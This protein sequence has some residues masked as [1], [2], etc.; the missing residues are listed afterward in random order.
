VAAQASRI[1][2]QASTVLF[3]RFPALVGSGRAAEVA[4]LH[5]AAMRYLVLLG[6][7][8]AVGLAVTAP[9]LVRLLYGPAYGAAAPALATLAL[10]SVVAFAAG[11]S[12][13]VLHALKRQ[14]RLL[15]Q[16]LLAAGA[17]VALAL[18]L[19]PLAGALGAALASALAQGLAS[20]LAIRAAVRLAGAG[21]P[22]AALARIV[23][24]A[25][26]MG[27]LAALP[28]LVL[29]GLGGLLG[30]VLV[31]APAY[32]LALRALRAL[33]A[34]DL[35]RARALVERLPTPARTG[36]LALARFLCREPVPAS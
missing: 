29:D 22:V 12:P 2:Y 5:A 31:G 11:A 10:G 18:V 23:G 9:A 13:A 26:L 33:S 17:D 1:P 7:P 20:L 36:G 24:A 14:D 27:T 8:L 3:P 15:R 21:V 35:D 4:G 30:A 32:P 6:A 25:L 19:I 16:G 34:E 28:A